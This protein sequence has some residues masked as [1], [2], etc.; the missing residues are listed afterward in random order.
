MSSIIVAGVTDS[1]VDYKS[2]PSRSVPCPTALHVIYSEGPV[3]LIS[4]ETQ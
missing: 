4:D 2:F 1:F 3:M